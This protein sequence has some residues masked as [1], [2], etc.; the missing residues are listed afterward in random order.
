MR[1]AWTRWEA[2]IRRSAVTAAV[3]AIVSRCHSTPLDC[4]R[5]VD[6]QLVFREPAVDRHARPVQTPRGFADVPAGRH[7]RGQQ[8]LPLVGSRLLG[9]AAYPGQRVV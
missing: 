6:W 2:T 7:E 5:V 4:H 1:E 8:L 9:L 3:S